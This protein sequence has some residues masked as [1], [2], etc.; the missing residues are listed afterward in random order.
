MHVFARRRVELNTDWAGVGGVVSQRVEHLGTRIDERLTAM[1]KQ[2]NTK[3]RRLELAH[4]ELG[5]VAAQNELETESCI[6]RT[7]FS[8]AATW[9]ASPREEG[10]HGAAFGYTTC[11]ATAGGMASFR[12]EAIKHQSTV[13]QHGGLNI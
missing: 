9:T 12:G 7:I 1:E 4:A 13:K 2:H 10:I 11:Q 5:K 6:E 3:I 8:E